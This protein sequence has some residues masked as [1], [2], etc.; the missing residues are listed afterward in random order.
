MS[1]LNLEDFKLQLPNDFKGNFSQA[2]FIEW[3]ECQIGIRYRY[4]IS[5]DNPLCG[6]DISDCNISVGKATL[7]NEVIEL[8]K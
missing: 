4:D 1:K 8:D 6:I 5:N 2:D 7:D 3:L